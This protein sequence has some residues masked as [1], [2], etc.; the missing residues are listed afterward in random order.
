MM[1]GGF[2]KKLFLFDVRTP[3]NG[4]SVNLNSDIESALWDPINQFN[5]LF[6]SENGYVTQCDARKLTD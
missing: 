1:T 2:D 4:L 3:A 6:S 5:V